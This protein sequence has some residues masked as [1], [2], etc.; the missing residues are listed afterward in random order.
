MAKPSS[1]TLC[2][3][4]NEDIS[5]VLQEEIVTLGKKGSATVN[6]N[7]EERGSEVRTQEGQRVHKECRKRWGVKY[8]I[9][10]TKSKEQINTPSPCKL[11]SQNKK[12]EEIS[13]D[14]IFCCQP[15]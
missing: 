13:Q 3:L 14:C 6:Q 1:D 8:Y 10:D 12:F 4:C 7:S 11:R 9:Q 15:A 2:V 5:G